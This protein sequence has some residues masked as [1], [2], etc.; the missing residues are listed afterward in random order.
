[1][2]AQITRES[3]RIDR[4]HK[5]AVAELAI[6]GLKPN[7][8]KIALAEINAVRDL[9]YQQIQNQFTPLMQRLESDIG[10]PSTG[11]FSLVGVRP[12]TPPK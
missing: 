9:G 2:Q 12:N 7:E 4:I 10:I 8:Y 6:R 5:D 3:T 1:M 11:G